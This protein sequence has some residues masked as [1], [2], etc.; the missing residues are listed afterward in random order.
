MANVLVWAD[1]P[2]VDIERA[3]AFYG[4][5]TGLP[6]VK[7]PGDDS[8]AIIQT[9]SDEG[10]AVSADLFVGGHPSHDGP[11]IYFGSGG[12]IDGMVQRAVAAGGRILDE[13]RFMGDM[14]GWIA[15]IED[16]E[17]NRIGIQQPAM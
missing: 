15:F 7:F 13:K 2:V 4:T 6:V 17:G 8:V 3:S 12:D 10:P 16:T 5:L 11:T 9:P 14:V 1:I